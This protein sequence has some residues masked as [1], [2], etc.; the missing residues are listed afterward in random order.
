M[1]LNLRRQNLTLAK[2]ADKVNLIIAKLDVN[3]AWA[4]LAVAIL[5][6]LAV[7][8]FLSN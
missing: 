7:D 3:L 2:Q 8:K 5:A 4:L 1:R 6:A